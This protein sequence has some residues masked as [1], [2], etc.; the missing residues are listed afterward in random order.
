MTSHERG[1]HD[2]EQEDLGGRVVGPEQVFEERGEGV[3]DEV[4]PG[5]RWC[6]TTLSKTQDPMTTR[7]MNPPI[8][9]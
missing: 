4:F 3:L 8:A 7:A 9:R 1:D 6:A 2:D 5:L